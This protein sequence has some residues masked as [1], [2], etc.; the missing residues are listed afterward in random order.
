VLE[1]INRSGW[2]SQHYESLLDNTHDQ[3]WKLLTWRIPRTIEQFNDLARCVNNVRE[4]TP[5]SLEDLF[6]NPLPR[7][8]RIKPWAYYPDE[9][10]ITVPNGWL[11]GYNDVDNRFSNWCSQWG[12]P[13]S[14]INIDSYRNVSRKVWRTKVDSRYSVKA[15]GIFHSIYGYDKLDYTAVDA[16]NNNV[17]ETVNGTT[18]RRKNAINNSLKEK[19]LFGSSGNLNRYRYAS[20]LDV[21]GAFNWLDDFYIGVEEAGYRYTP[22]IEESPSISIRTGTYYGNPAFDDGYSAIANDWYDAQMLYRLPD[23]NGDWMETLNDNAHFRLMDLN[24]GD[25]LITVHV[26]SDPDTIASPNEY[27][28][29]DMNY[30]SNARRYGVIAL[31]GSTADFISYGPNKLMPIDTTNGKDVWQSIPYFSATYPCTIICSAEPYY[32]HS[33]VTPFP[34][35]DAEYES[36]S[37]VSPTKVPLFVKRIETTDYPVTVDKINTWSGRSLNAWH[38]QIIKHSGVLRE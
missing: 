11:L 17:T 5:V 13:V 22:T 7:D 23:T 29:H 19:I 20:Y 32:S 26:Q 21:A 28:V 2:W 16:L 15:G 8:M 10:G 25:D 14:T 38:V 4:V 3:T 33:Y 24:A 35:Y 31:A 18:Y 34:D 36:F 27:L 37:T 6:K 9:L 1:N 12:I 30:S